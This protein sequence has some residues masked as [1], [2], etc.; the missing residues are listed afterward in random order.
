M[1]D[2]FFSPT[3]LTAAKAPIPRLPQCGKCKLNLGCKSPKMP[4]AGKGRKGILVV[5]EAP[6]KTEDDENL[7]FVGTTGT[8]LREVMR[9]FGVDLFKDCWVTNAL[10]CRPPNNRISNPRS[11]D[12]CRPNVVKAVEDYRPEVVVLLG[13]HAV[14]SLIGTYLWKENDPG[15]IGRWAGFRIP[16]QKLNAWVYPTYHPSDVLREQSNGN[17]VVRMH[18]EEHLET[19]LSL[20]GRPWDEVPDYG[21]RVSVAMNP[22][23][24]QVTL[25]RL[26]R[27][28]KLI[29]FDYET[30]RLKPDSADSE[31][32]CCSISDGETT[33]AYPWYGPA[34]AETR[35]ILTDPSIGKIAS[36]AKFEHRWTW[37]DLGVRV[38]GWRWDTMLAAHALDARKGITGLKFNA[39]VRLGVE[40]YSSHVEEYLYARTGNERNHIREAGFEEILRY[41]GQDSL[42][43]YLVAKHQAAEMG[44]GFR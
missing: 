1:P 3:S 16:S 25:N 39:F 8:M 7:P 28:A 11:V 6:D 26:R 21:K 18:F 15:G 37:K 5:G 38:R 30:D 9:K 20:K 32:V 4:V 17:P 24:A 14:R 2:G 23:M 29:A 13:N 43:E 31:I 22:N 42:C 10:I 40:D 34:I 19:A 27:S 33:V 35:E 44:V 41:C 36:N 12:Y